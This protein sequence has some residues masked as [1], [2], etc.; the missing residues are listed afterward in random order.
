MRR[1]IHIANSRIPTEKAHGLQMMKLCETFALEGNDVTMLAPSRKNKIKTD[2]Y[3]FYNVS[4]NFKVVYIKCPDLVDWGPTGFMLTT[5]IFGLLAV[6][7]VLKRKT[8]WV[9][10]RDIAALWILSW[11]NKKFIF[12]IHD[13]QRKT[14]AARVLKKCTG[15]IS[16]NRALISLHKEYAGRDMPTLHAP[17][18]VSINEFPTDKNKER[19]RQDLGLSAERKIVLYAG[20]LYAYKGGDTLADAAVSL[21]QV[22]FV[23]VGG[24]ENDINRFRG[25]YGSFENIKI[26]GHKP[27]D[28]VPYYLKAADLLV[29]PNTAKDT[30]SLL[31]TSPIKLFE[32]MASGT[33]ILASD[34]PSIRE[35][36]DE[37]TGFFFEPDSSASLQASILDIFKN[38]AEAA[39]RASQA[40]KEVQKYSYIERAR[41]VLKFMHSLEAGEAS[42]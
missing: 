19:I 13:D 39:K 41:R 28:M 2:P 7:E 34:I 31:Y 5:W 16:T 22:D 26:L 32:Y 33:A 3:K 24:M 27:H 4:K 21:P 15:L 42:K 1:I 9:Y 20:H 38:G 23:F 10:S 25:K 29:L 40:A 14:G 11:T 30:F 17:S 18:S 8:D 36:L 12:E 35:I 37:S 6:I